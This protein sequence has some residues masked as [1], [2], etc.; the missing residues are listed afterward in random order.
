MKLTT[1]ETGKPNGITNT[2]QKEYQI[3]IIN[4]SVLY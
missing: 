1:R 4:M 3:H 2:L